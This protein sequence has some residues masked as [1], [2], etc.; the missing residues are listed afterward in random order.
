MGWDYIDAPS[1]A[2]GVLAL[3]ASPRA[4]RRAVYELGL[5]RCVSHRELLAAI[6]GVAPARLELAAFEHRFAPVSLLPL[7][8]AAA[9]APLP[10]GAPHVRSLPPEHWLHTRPMQVEHMRDEFGWKATEFAEAVAEYMAW[11]RDLGSH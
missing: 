7:S 4:P 8:G 6:A 3:L 1:A 9:A 11:L 2:R 10:S 5:G